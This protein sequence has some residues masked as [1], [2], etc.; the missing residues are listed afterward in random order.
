[1]KRYVKTPPITTKEVSIGLEYMPEYSTSEARAKFK[2]IM[3]QE[4]PV[5]I[6]RMGGDRKLVIDLKDYKRL[7]E[8]LSTPGLAMEIATQ[9]I[10][11]LKNRQQ[12]KKANKISDD[13]AQQIIDLLQRLL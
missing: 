2:E 3:D 8:A 9:G 1:M 13:K 5:L 11:R 12:Q 6:T 10:E 4:R 7:I